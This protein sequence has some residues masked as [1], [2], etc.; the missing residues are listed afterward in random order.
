M[1]CPLCGR[2]RPLTKHHLIPATLHKNKWFRKR[3][4]KEELGAGV[5]VCRDCHSAI[6]KYIPSEKELGRNYNTIGKLKEHRE[7]RKYT[8]WLARQRRP[9]R[10]KVKK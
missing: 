6:H 5:M 10:Y 3:F 9:G 2:D 7:L 8:K 1:S 4:T